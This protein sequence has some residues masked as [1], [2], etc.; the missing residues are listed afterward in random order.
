MCKQVL[1]N[2]PCGHKAFIGECEK[3]KL[4]PLK[5][6]GEK[7]GKKPKCPVCAKSWLAME[8]GRIG[9]VKGWDFGVEGWGW[10]FGTW[11][12]GGYGLWGLV[13]WSWIF[14]FSYD[15][16]FGSVDLWFRIFVLILQYL[17]LRGMIVMECFAD[18]E[19]G[20]GG[21]GG[22]REQ[23]V[24][25]QD[26][27]RHLGSVQLSIYTN[28]MGILLWWRRW[29]FEWYGVSFLTWEDWVILVPD[30]AKMMYVVVKG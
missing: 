2:S 26:C 15:F 24:Y 29:G 7:A 8:T 11:F 23:V 20:S 16:G 30:P 25:D 5:A 27:E 3:G 19:R 18:W 9:S 12:T 13:F 1:P 4:C 6:A 21:F 28:F 14:G 10:G 17:G 22:R